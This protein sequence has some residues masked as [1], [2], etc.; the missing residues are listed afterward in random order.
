MLLLLRLLLRC[1]ALRLLLRTRCLLAGRLVVLLLAATLIVGIATLIVAIA[2]LLALRTATEQLQGALHVHH[3]FGGIAL[4]AVF[5]VP[6]TGLQLAFDVALGAFAQ[7]LTGNLGHLAEQH[8]TVPFGTLLALTRLL[9]HP[10]LTG[11][12]A[13]VGHGVA[14]AQVANFGILTA[15]ADQND[16]VY[17]TGHNILL[18]FARRRG[19]VH[20]SLQ[21]RA[22]Q[23]FRIQ[24]DV[25]RSFIAD[26]YDVGHTWH[27]HQA[28]GKRRI[29]QCS[30][31]QWQ[32]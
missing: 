7:V 14:V 3:D 6:A 15:G 25:D 31:A 21:G 13:Q 24:F 16:F 11:G 19:W 32:A 20:Q 27:G 4:H 12:Q 23:N 9:V 5:V 10:L 2:A 26:H 17:P 18:G 28:R 29:L 22:V 30:G 8:H 1:L